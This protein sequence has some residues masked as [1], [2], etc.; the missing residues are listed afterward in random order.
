MVVTRSPELNRVSL[1]FADKAAER[2]FQDQYFRDNL[3]Y[4]RTAHVVG[5][6]AWAFFGLYRSAGVITEVHVVLHFGVAIPIVAAGLAL[7]YARWYAR[8]W[9]PAIVAL[10]VANSALVEMPGW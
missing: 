6:A 9:Q 1:R 8:V 5:I 7:T 4:I 2:R 10:V 3:P